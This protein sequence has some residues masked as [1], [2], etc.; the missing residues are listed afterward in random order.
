MTVSHSAP[1]TQTTEPAG[2]TRI[3]MIATPAALMV[4]ALAVIFTS[5]GLGYWT[6]LG[7]G[8]GFFPFWIGILLGT[9]SLVWLVQAL[10]GNPNVVPQPEEAVI[11]DTAVLSTA[12]TAKKRPIW[13]VLLSLVAVASL[14]E[15]LGFQL[16]MFAF[17]LFQ[18]KFQ[19]GRKWVSSLI[20]AVA[21]S[22]GVYHLFTDL[23][24][25]TLP[26]SSIGLLDSLGL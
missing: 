19:G 25:V 15:I 10:R 3:L 2:S 26:T 13:I 18:L 20:I 12:P 17:L 16:S 7:P 11:P 9:S 6:T 5:N 23:L 1:P 24:Q 14:L 8:P 22:F 21:G 4:L